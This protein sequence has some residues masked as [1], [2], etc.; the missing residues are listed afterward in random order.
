MFPAVTIE[1]TRVDR[2]TADLTP[3]LFML[4]NR[5]CEIMSIIP[6]GI[7]SGVYKFGQLR[8]GNHV[9]ISFLQKLSSHGNG[10]TAF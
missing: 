6:K 1:D 3:I 9:L 7:L 4:T 8:K 5:R 2:S 10:D